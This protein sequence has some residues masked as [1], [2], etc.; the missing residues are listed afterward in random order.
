MN[1]KQKFLLSE[2]NVFHNERNVWNKKPRL[3][4]LNTLNKTLKQRERERRKE[5][6]KKENIL[7][8]LTSKRN[9]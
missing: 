3:S 9:L 6:R 4:K 1:Y 8:R 7:L 2:R 5:E